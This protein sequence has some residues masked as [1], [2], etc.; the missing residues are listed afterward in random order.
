MISD[1]FKKDCQGK[2]VSE[3]EFATLNNNKFTSINKV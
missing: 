2:R 1:Y 3:R